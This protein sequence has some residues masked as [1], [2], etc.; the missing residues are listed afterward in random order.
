[1]AVLRNVSETVHNWA[2]IAYEAAAD[3]AAWPRLMTSLVR[4]TG[5]S[6]GALFTPFELIPERRLGMSCGSVT[7]DSV[8]EWLTQWRHDDPWNNAPS[9]ARLFARPGSVRHGHEFLPDAELIRTAYYNDFSR[10]RESGRLISL[11]VCGVGDPLAPATTLSLLRPLSTQAFDPSVRAALRAFWPH[12][13]GALYSRS[14]LGQIRRAQAVA[15][16]VLALFPHAA[17]LVRGDATVL[18][19]N[20]AAE[21]LARRRGP[22]QLHWARLGR[23]GDV[24]ARRVEDAVASAARGLGRDLPTVVEDE[25]GSR[26][27]TLCVI[28]LSG[29]HEL[30][31]AWPSARALVLLQ[32]TPQVPPISSV[33]RLHARHG[34]TRAECRVLTGLAEGLSVRELANALQLS[35]ATVR[36]HLRAL[37]AKTGCQRQGG[38]IRLVLTG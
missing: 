28:S 32:L 19:A 3:E 11:N 23:I 9:H 7:R 24:D 4:A 31:A 30:L 13:R 10:P 15:S 14:S 2:A 5:A 6:G 37:F 34:L 17:W 33:E 25:A 29:A 35:E 20:R 36:T 12:L 26:R 38:L 22:V 16:A 1:M 18:C 21:D 8:S 27:A